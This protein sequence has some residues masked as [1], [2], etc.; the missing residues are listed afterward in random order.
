MRTF[1]SQGETRTAAISLILAQ[2]DIFYQMRHVRPV[3][4]FDDIFSELDRQRAQQL[5]EWSSQYHQVFV[6]TAR[7]EDVAGWQPEGLR[8]WEVKQGEFEAVA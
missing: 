7:R 1:S 4:F 8:A 6:A 2:S 5:Q 3:L